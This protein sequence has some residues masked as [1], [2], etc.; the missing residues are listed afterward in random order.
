MLRQK[1]ARTKLL[2]LDVDGVMTDGRI[3]MNDRGEET[4]CFDVK[5]GQGLKM[6]LSSGIEVVIITGRNSKVVS[7]RAHELGIK[8]VYQG[9]KE[10]NGLCRQLI[11][12]KALNKEDV[13]YMGDDLPD[14]AAFHECGLSIAVSDA[15]GEVCTSADLITKKRGGRGAVREVCEWIL[16]CQGKW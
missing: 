7:H 16:K 11:K 10:K 6:L 8:E 5:D 3:I 4:K 1:A 15:A 12:G 9:V 13:C 2:F 14:I